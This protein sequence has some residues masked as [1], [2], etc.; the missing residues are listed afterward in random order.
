MWE[1]GTRYVLAYFYSEQEEARRQA[2]PAFYIH[3]Q[4]S[5]PQVH[6]YSVIPALPHPIHI[7]SSLCCFPIANVLDLRT[8]FLSPNLWLLSYTLSVG[9]WGWCGDSA[10]KL[11]SSAKRRLLSKI[12]YLA[13]TSFPENSLPS[14]SWLPEAGLT[15]L[16]TIR[17]IPALH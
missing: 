6:K 5:N 2:N 11:I 7:L 14:L 3:L 16:S 8:L 10:T 17:I 15:D 4:L 13:Y 12:V 1:E 9:F